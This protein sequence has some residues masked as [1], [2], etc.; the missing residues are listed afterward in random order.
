MAAGT[1]GGVTGADDQAAACAWVTQEDREALQVLPDQAR[2]DRGD[3]RFEAQRTVRHPFSERTGNDLSRNLDH[4]AQDPEAKGL[5]TGEDAASAAGGSRRL[6]VLT[7]PSRSIAAR[8]TRLI[9]SL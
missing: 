8:S 4:S 1:H 5:N 3:D 9:V 6:E 7:A 2:P